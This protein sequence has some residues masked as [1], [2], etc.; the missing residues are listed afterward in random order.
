MYKTSVPLMRFFERQEDNIREARRL[1]AS[2]VFLCVGR[3][4]GD[5]AAN[6]AELARLAENI[7]FYEAAG[8]EVGVWCSTI[9]HGG[10]LAGDCGG[11][12]QG[13]TNNIIGLKGVST[14]DS[15]CPLDPA[16]SDAICS[17]VRG[18]AKAGAKMI[19]LDDDFR[20][21][22]RSDCGCTCERH[23]TEYRRR[24]GENIARE[25]ILTKAF[26]GGANRY[27]DVWYDL[28]GDTLRVFARQLRTAVDS[29]DP[30]IRLGACACISVWDA[31]GVDSIEIARI[32][33]GNTKPFM[34][35]I[36]APYWPTTWGPPCQHLQYVAELERMQRHWCE[37]TGI[38]I[39]GEGDVYPRP[40]HFVP[41]AYLEAFDTILR[42]DGGF[43]GILKYGV[44]Y[45]L[46]PR[47]ETGYA[48][49]AERSGPLY[50]EIEK[51]FVGKT[52]IGVGV[53]CTMKKIRGRVFSDPEKE[54]GA[55]YDDGFFQPEQLLLT[56][57][58]IPMTYGAAPVTAAFG[59]NAKYLQ[60]QPYGLLLDAAAALILEKRGVDTGLASAAPYAPA[61]IFGEYFFE[62]NETVYL[63]DAV[64]LMKLT[65]KPGAIPLSE[66]RGE[67][68]APSA[69]CYENAQGM[70][71]CI[72]G[73]DAERAKKNARLFRNYC[74]QNQLLSSLAWLGRA[75][76][77]AVCAK[78]PDLYLLCKR[79]GGSM[80][81]GLWNLF[82]DAVLSPVITLD[83]SY[84]RVEFINCTGT[85][86]GNR[87][88][89]SADIPAYSFAGFEVFEQG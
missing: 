44:D 50:T 67:A 49:R 32:L 69:L 15:F 84:G 8:F 52:T 75:P 42:A 59:E 63:A 85:L 65:P 54:I 73:F 55:N 61:A 78:N 62:E 70:R 83:K 29:V 46:S 43:D 23:L 64:G 2:R 57:N 37:G 25:E 56:D 31:D 22:T 74:R 6:R 28:M 79:G 89:L 4:L 12:P 20:L 11:L 77:P 60:V 66:F 14:D 48:D 24:L 16:F 27:R 88:C 21:S 47:Y 87:V 33:A 3:G 26:S 36:G 7:P 9:G 82:P 19:M 58:S 1:G 41:A 39:F 86:N 30:S 53:A 72:L 68:D 71:F 35:F 10:P 34:R 81:V 13:G 18:I 5:E 38:E 76:L 40:R 51:H 45:R 17:R 80:A